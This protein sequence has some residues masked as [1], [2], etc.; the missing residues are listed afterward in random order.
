MNS[1]VML[2]F[3]IL[4]LCAT[5]LTSCTTTTPETVTV[6]EVVYKPIELDISDS[7]QI[8]FDTRP[9]LAPDLEVDDSLSP[10]QQAAM[11][12]LAYKAWGEAWQSYAARLEDYVTL[13]QGTL[14]NPTKEVASAPE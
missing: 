3:K 14:K 11:Y 9:V 5:L 6:T 12:L 4:M 13:L 10:T 8:L 7:V 2:T 1:S